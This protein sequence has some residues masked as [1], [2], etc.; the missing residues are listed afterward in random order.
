MAGTG[1]A[2]GVA[3][4]KFTADYKQFVQGLGA[5]GTSAATLGSKVTAVGTRM[6]SIGKAGLVAFAGL[7]MAIGAVIKTAADF[8]KGFHE[9]QTMMGDASS[10]QIA[11]LRKDILDLSMDF[12]QKLPDALRASYNALSASVPE[13]NLVSFLQVAGKAAS[14]GVTDINTTVDAL[15]TVVNSYGEKLA[16]L[17]DYTQRAAS[18]SDMLF[19]IVKGGKTTMAEL[20]DSIGTVASIAAS[21]NITL[22]ELGA[23]FATMTA[24]GMS[25]AISTTA[26]RATIASLL[27]PADEAAKKFEELGINL[28]GFREGEW[29]FASSCR[30]LIRI[31]INSR[32]DIM[33]CPATGRGKGTGSE[34]ACFSP[35][36]CL[37]PL[38]V[39][40]RSRRRVSRPA[41]SPL[42]VT[43]HGQHRGQAR[44]NSMA[45]PVPC[46]CPRC[47]KLP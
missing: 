36:R 31:P 17:G 8:E 11:T 38:L 44:P 37:S 10:D 6:S 25:T 32:A 29:F 47:A 39:A 41:L 42:L 20:S 7:G 2:L 14:A 21:A 26:I 45:E 40:P 1:T 12:G 23:M 24:K 18:V 15:T 28:E 46:A 9:V 35:R 27:T 34:A 3:V 16:Y 19:A 4:V 13:E 22:D 43:P 5:M 33:F 30:H